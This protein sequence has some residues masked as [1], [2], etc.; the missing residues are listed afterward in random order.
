MSQIRIKRSPNA[1]AP[2]SLGPGELAW[3]EGSKTLYIGTIAG[4]LLAIGGDGAG[5]LKANQPITVTGDVAGSGTTAINLTLGDVIAA[6][7]GAKISY[8][9]K[10]R[11]VGSG[12]LARSDIPSLAIDTVEGLQNA[13]NSKAQLD[14]SGKIPVSALPDLAISDTFV[15]A[16]QAEMLA[17]V[18]QRGDIAIRSDI[19]DDFILRGNDPT[20]LANWQKFLH[21]SSQNNGIVTINNKSGSAVMLNAADVPFQATGNIAAANLQSALAELD[22][23]KL[24][25]DRDIAFTGDVA[26]TGS[27]GSAGISLTLKSVVAAGTASKISFNA[28]GLVTA[29]AALTAGDIPSL[30]IGQISGLQVALD[31]KVGVNDVI[32]GGLY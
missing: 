24:A 1:T 12:V 16:S 3:S 14:A 25:L 20:V 27:A 29:S 15:V 19:N 10:G 5:F 30:P 7:T 11:V 32:D 31:N 22:A 9:A 6:G 13:L 17:L 18:A 28:K 26:G 4:G 23:E 21:P 8:D 2:S